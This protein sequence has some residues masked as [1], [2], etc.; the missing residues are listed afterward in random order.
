MK[1]LLFCAS[2]SIA[3]IS[4]KDEKADKTT[5][6]ISKDSAAASNNDTSSMMAKTDTSSAMAAPMDSAAMMKAWQ[7]YMT[8]GEPHKMMAMNN[9]T[10]NEEVKMYMSPGAPPEVMNATATN[11]M[12]L[13][14]LYQVS[15]TKGSYNGMPFEGRS[16]LGYNNQTK[17]YQ[18]TWIDNM[19]SGMLVM[20]GTYDDA[21]K[22]L[23]LTGKETDPMTGKENPVRQTMKFIDDKNHLIEMYATRDGKE[24]KTMEIKLTKK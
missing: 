23:T 16:T 10:W 17:K 8:P 4:C 9:G 13:N 7:A 22:T 6:V 21:N 1:K 5:Y 15:V 20:D 11:S 24:S 12:A 3:F 2:L 19:G 18:N 14:G